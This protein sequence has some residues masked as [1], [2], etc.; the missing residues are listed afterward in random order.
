MLAIAGG[1]LIASGLSAIFVARILQSQV[2]KEN[3]WEKVAG[4]I[5]RACVRFDG[6][7]FDPDFEYVYYTKGRQFRGNRLRSLMISVNWRSPSE[8]AVARYPSGMPVVVFVNPNYP[9]DAV[10]EPG[11]D[12][13]FL[14]FIITLASFVLLAG[15]WLVV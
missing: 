3:E 10:L 7:Y 5:T 15:I 6:E 11:G 9:R 8:K 4:T 12:E 2:R 1:L 14:P 13:Q